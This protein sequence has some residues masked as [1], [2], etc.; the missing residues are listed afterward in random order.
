MKLKS[1]TN[2]YVDV[3]DKRK[4]QGWSVTNIYCAHDHKMDEEENL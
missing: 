3:K 2:S 4:I 1:L